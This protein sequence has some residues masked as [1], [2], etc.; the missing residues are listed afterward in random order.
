MSRRPLNLPSFASGLSAR[1]L[2]LTVFFVMLAEVLIYAPSIARYRL[3]YLQEKLS[4]GH[5]ATLTL[6]MT[7]DEQLRLEMRRDLLNILD[8]HMVDI[9][10]PGGYDLM[11][12]DD[13]LPTVDLAVDLREQ[14][15][16]GLIWDALDTLAHDGNRV[17]AVRGTAPKDPRAE[18]TMYV[19][20]WPLR[21]E[22]WDYSSRILVLSIGISLFTAALVF[23]ALQWLTVRPIRRMSESMDRFAENPEDVTRTIA[24]SRRSDEIGFAQRHLADMQNSLR[25]ALRQKNALAALGAAVAK[26]NHDLRNI[27]SSALLVSDSLA[28]S[29]DPEA[30]RQAP[31]VATAIERAIRLCGDV[32][33]FARQDAPKPRPSRFGLNELIDEIVADLTARYPDATIMVNLDRDLVLNVD[34]EHMRRA[35]DNVI[36]NA[37]EAGARTIGLEATL[38]DTWLTLDISDDGPGIPAKIAERLFTPFSGSVKDGGSGLGLAIARELVTAQGGFII[39]ASTGPEGTVFRITLPAMALAA[40]GAHAA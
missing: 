32:L 19:D 24:P 7:P 1:L 36:R 5:L 4:D 15:F 30:Q 23:L 29:A 38:G 9:S 26:I 2:V 10:W 3:E 8:A 17:I 39:L 16:F 34:H 31:K 37:L 33:S 13:D 27:L 6:R 35:L 14:T 22:M 20:E 11:V 12:A 21:M 40:E 25:D 18:V 28:S